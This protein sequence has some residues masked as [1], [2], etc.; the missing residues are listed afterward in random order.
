MKKCVIFAA[1]QDNVDN[2]KLCG[3]EFVICADAGFLVAKRQGIKP[4]IV[5]GDFDSFD[6]TQLDDTLSVTFPKRKDD[7]D[8]MLAIKYGMQCD[9]TDFTIYGALGGKRLDHTVA[10]FSTLSF[11]ADNSLSGKLV[12]GKTCVTLLSKGE[13]IIENSGG[14]LSLFPYGCDCINVTLDGTEYDGEVMLTASF[15]IGVSNEFK[16]H[17]AKITVTAQ[18]DTGRV[19]LIQTPKN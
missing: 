15:P 3:D 5:L 6:K 12:S 17:N 14:Y 4:D 18:N 8:L 9:C 19:L 13:H 7:T 2:I 1:S 10:A 16:Q 11:L